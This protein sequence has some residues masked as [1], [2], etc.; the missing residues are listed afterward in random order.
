VLELEL[1]GPVAT[2]CEAPVDVAVDLP[3]AELFDEDSDELVEVVIVVE[4]AVVAAAARPAVIVTSCPPSS[5]PPFENEVVATEEVAEPE[6]L[7][8][9]VALQTP[10][11]ELVIT[12]PSSTFSLSPA[13]S[14]RIWYW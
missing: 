2:V 7:P 1:L 3:D 8:R 10:L 13:P 6:T 14:S 4:G 11:S 12:H 5:E 9:A